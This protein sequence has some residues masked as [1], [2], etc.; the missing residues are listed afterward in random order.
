M[1]LI[2]PHLMICTQ[3]GSRTPEFDFVHGNRRIGGIQFRKKRSLYAVVFTEHIR[4]HLEPSKEFGRK[5]Y[6][7][8]DSITNEEI[9]M[10][11]FSFFG[12]KIDVRFRYLYPGEIFHFRAKGIFPFVSYQWE[13]QDGEVFCESDPVGFLK[14][15]GKIS[16]NPASLARYNLE[17]FSVLSVYLMRVMRYRSRKSSRW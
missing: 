5:E 10:M 12:R 13:N 11:E 4:W 17:I 9:G 16:M 7:I 1:S 15:E 2:Q 14:K 6:S 3:S 8:F